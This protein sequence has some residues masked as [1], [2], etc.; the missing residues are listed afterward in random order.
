MEEARAL[1]TSTYH[2]IPDGA[3]KSFLDINVTAYTSP[4]ELRVLVCSTMAS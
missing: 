3:M 4:A 1:V 2:A